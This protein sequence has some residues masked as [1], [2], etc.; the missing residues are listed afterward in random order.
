MT[1]PSG[2][3]WPSHARWILLG[4]PPL[5]RPRAG[6][7]SPLFGRRPQLVGPDDR[8]VDRHQS[9]DIARRVRLGLGGPQHP[10]EGPVRRPPA[11]TGVECGPRPV[12]F[13]HVPPGRPGPELPH[14]PIQGIRRSSSRFRPRNGSGSNARAGANAWQQITADHRSRATPGRG[15][16][17][18]GSLRGPDEAGPMETRLG[19]REAGV[20]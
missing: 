13:G 5:D 20:S 6:S 9:V 1:K 14:D 2:R 3:P 16:S 8:G 18:R 15:A 11:K 19:G 7:R 17:H 4:R 12:S 10:V